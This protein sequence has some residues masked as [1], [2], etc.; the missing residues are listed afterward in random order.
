MNKVDTGRRRR[1][2]N[3]AGGDREW[4]EWSTRAFSS[5]ASAVAERGRTRSSVLERD[6]HEE[7]EEDEEDLVERPGPD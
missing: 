1:T 4:E 7:A 5:N 6:D 2:R 3:R